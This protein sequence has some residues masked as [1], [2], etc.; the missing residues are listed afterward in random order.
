[1]KHLSLTIFTLLL[2]SCQKE[3]KGKQPILLADREAPIGWVYLRI[4]ADSTFEFESGGLRDKNIYPGKA[5]ITK[6][7]IFFHYKDSIAYAGTKAVYN[8]GSVVY[9]DGENGIHES[10]EIKLSKLRK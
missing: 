9:T 2:F 7:T 5:E 8:K 4:Y 3:L 1:M 6:D 10:L